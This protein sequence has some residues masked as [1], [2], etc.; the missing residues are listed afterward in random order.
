M[1][2]LGYTGVQTPSGKF[3]I[4]LPGKPIVD[5]KRQF[6]TKWDFV[7]ALKPISEDVGKE[8]GIDP[9]IVMAHAILETGYGSKVKGN[10]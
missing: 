5:Y 6:E 4:D 8:L 10:N 3:Y 9:R 7:T 2:K 1:E